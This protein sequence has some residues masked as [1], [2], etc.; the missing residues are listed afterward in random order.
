MITQTNIA[1]F[2]TG[3]LAAALFSSTDTV[4]DEDSNETEVVE[5]DQYEWA[6]GEAESLHDDCKTFIEAH[7]IDLEAYTEF[8]SEQGATDGSDPWAQAGHDFWLNR[9]GHGAGFWSRGAGELG[10]R[11]ASAV[12]HGTEYP[13][14]DLYL[15]ENKEVCS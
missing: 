12:G 6:E 9:N 14:I 1:A 11:L 7:A 15:N 8:L 2:I 3:Y 4:L 13:G 5:L 10:E